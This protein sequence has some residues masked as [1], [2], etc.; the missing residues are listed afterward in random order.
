MQQY[1]KYLLVLCYTCGIQF[2]YT[3]SRNILQFSGL[4]TSVGSELPVAYVTVKN[5]SF[6]N[7]TFISNNDGYF[8]FVAHSGDTIQFSSV[9][10]EPLTY[11][12]P[13]V[14]DDKFTAH[15]QMRSL[16]IELPAVT[17]FPWASYEDYLAD[18]MGMKEGYDP[19]AS[20][21]SNLSPDAMAAL[22]RIVPRNADEIQNFNSIQRHINMSN[23]NINQRY[24]NPLLNP[25]GWAQLI[26]QIQ[27]GD[28][29]RQKLKY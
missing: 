25:F 23:K 11:I 3:Q 17:P 8:S 6:N 27:R 28:Y 5:T 7:Q 19:V 26:N 13:T 29:S 15:I 10:Y 14:S 20:A 21:R 12:I 18:F 4:I 2:G 16:V 1:I 22:A 9:G 24:A